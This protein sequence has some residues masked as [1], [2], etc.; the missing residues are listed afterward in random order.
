[1]DEGLMSK[2]AEDAYGKLTKK[3]QWEIRKQSRKNFIKKAMAK[4]V[5]KVEAAMFFDSQIAVEK[6]EVE[7]AEM[8]EQLLQW[9]PTPDEEN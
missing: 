8:G 4:G 6:Q 1:M 3:E 7:A 2:K 9:E 5:P